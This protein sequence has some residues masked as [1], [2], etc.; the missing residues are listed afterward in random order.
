MSCEVGG[1]EVE[2]DL[3]IFEAVL[4]DRLTFGI[5]HRN[6]MGAGHINKLIEQ[7]HVTLSA[8]EHKFG[9]VLVG[10]CFFPKNGV[11][12]EE[13]GLGEGCFPVVFS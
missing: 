12:I 8:Y 7:Q 11:A 6:R 4:G 3:N 5:N 1:G 9:A 2:G 13:F 10:Q